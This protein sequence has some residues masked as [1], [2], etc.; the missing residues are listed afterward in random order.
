MNI[1]FVFKERFKF[2]KEK[3]K[4]PRGEKAKCV[5]RVYRKESK[6]RGYKKL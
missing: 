3:I 4:N 2:L 1:I 5:M 6:R